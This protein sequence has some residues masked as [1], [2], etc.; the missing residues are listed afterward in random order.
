MVAVLAS[1]EGQRMK[2]EDKL[3]MGRECMRLEELAGFAAVVPR[4]TKGVAIGA[5]GRAAC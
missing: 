1:W 2:K 3:D 5:F 4:A